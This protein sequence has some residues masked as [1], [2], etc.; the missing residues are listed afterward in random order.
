MMV[1]FKGSTVMVVID[2]NIRNI[3]CYERLSMLAL[4]KKESTTYAVSASK[5]GCSGP[6]NIGVEDG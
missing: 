2:V 5:V 3:Y 1:P 4:G 6:P